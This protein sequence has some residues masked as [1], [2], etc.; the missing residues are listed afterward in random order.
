MS[1]RQWQQRVRIIAKDSGS[2]YDPDVVSTFLRLVIG[3]KL[4]VKG[5]AEQSSNL[6]LQPGLSKSR[7]ITRKALAAAPIL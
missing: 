5:W 6:N 4:H 7:T 1:E 2:F 3:G